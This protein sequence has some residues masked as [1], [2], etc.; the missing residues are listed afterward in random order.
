M[1]FPASPKE[2]VPILKGGD[3]KHFQFPRKVVLRSSRRLI[4]VS[5]SVDH[6]AREGFPFLIFLHIS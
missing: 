5:T 2:S 1:F 4:F 3:E 6:N